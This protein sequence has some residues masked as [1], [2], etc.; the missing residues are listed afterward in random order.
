MCDQS[1]MTSSSGPGAHQRDP[2]RR[3]AGEIEGP[4]RTPRRARASTRRSTVLGQ[5]SVKSCSCQPISTLVAEY[6]VR[7]ALGV[8]AIGG[9]QNGMARD[10]SSNAAR[11]R[12]SST[13]PVIR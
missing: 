9:A 8:H 3:V 13:A 2:Q 12:A 7:L 5:T 4:C 11:S 6:L 1:S 10:D